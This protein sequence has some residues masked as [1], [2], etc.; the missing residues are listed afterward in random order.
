MVT[1]VGLK[2]YPQT[3]NILLLKFFYRLEK[4]CPNF[5]IPVFF[6]KHSVP[7]DRYGYSNHPKRTVSPK[8]SHVRGHCSFGLVTVTVSVPRYIHFQN[9]TGYL[10]PRDC[11]VLSTFVDLQLLQRQGTIQISLSRAVYYF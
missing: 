4:I 10:Y 9:N 11:L 8:C 3:Q 6:L 7:G 5:P 2:C 1:V